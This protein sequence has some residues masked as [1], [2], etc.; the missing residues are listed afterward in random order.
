MLLNISNTNE[1]CMNLK[2]RIK[3]ARETANLNKSQ[4]ARRL[5]VHPSTC[6][7]WEARSGTSPTIQHL[8]EAAIVLGVRVEWLGTGRGEMK[9]A[10]NVRE[11]APCYQV[12][13]PALSTDERRVLDG[14]RALAPKKKKV[15]LDFVLMK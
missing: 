13:S 9:Y 2:N 15:M 14:Y 6:I 10:E 11:P 3:I 8:I 12:E 1:L 7:Q 5:G 4:F